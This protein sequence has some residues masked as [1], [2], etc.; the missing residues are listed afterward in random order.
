MLYYNEY[1]KLND[2]IITGEDRKYSMFYRDF[3]SNEIHN[4]LKS[5]GFSRNNS[6][7]FPTKGTN[8]AYLFNAD[9]PILIDETCYDQFMVQ[10]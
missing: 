2:G 9:G 6:F 1:T 5:T 4:I 8:Q 3:S 10:L 7:K